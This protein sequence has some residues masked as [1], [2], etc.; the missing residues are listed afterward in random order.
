MLGK[1]L[2]KVRSLVVINKFS[3][4]KVFINFTD[5]YR[6]SDDIIFCGRNEVKIVKLGSDDVVVKSFKQPGFMRKFFY[7]F[8]TSSKAKRS[9]E[10]SLKLR[11]LNI[12]C[13]EPIAYIEYGSSFKLEQSYFISEKVDYFCTL[14]EVLIDQSFQDRDSILDK[15][16]CFVCELHSKNIL[17]LDLSPGN[18]LIREKSPGILTFVLVDLNRMTFKRLNLKQKISNFSRLI[19]SES[20]L[21]LISKCYSKYSKLDE[22]LIFTSMRQSCIRWN[23]FLTVKNRVKSLIKGN[24]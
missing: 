12:N 8:L 15:F 19:F 2:G 13:P 17:H 24:L 23:R 3:G 11:A 4:N 21:K 22:D 7:G 5:H 18:V 10:N 9:Y 6:N 16:T 1:E 20:D 14:R